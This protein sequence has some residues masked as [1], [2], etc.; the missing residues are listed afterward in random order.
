MPN[1]APSQGMS[2]WD[3]LDELRAVILRS[4]AATLLVAVAA[5]SVKDLLFAFLLAPSENGFI[6]YRV[7]ARIAAMTGGQ[8]GNFSVTLINTQL[9]SQFL[10]HVQAAFC[11]GILGA[12]PYILYQLFRF[13]S[14]ALYASERHFASRAVVWGYLL[15]MIGAATSYLIIFPLTFR[16]LGTYQVQPDVDNLINLSSYISTLLTLTLSMGIFFEMPVLIW[17]FGRMGWIDAHFLRRYRRHAVVIILIIAAIITPTTDVV[18][19]LAVSLPLWL[20]YEASI[21]TVRSKKV[22]VEKP[23]DC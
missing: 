8:L 21:F 7:L 4:L 2:F 10:I 14:P 3:H 1:E 22:G 13:L 19:L 23:L 15:F 18:T 17:L 11:I 20:L 6:T 16:F 5:F 9:A 12:S